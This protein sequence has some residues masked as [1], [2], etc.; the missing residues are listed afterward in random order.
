MHGRPRDYQQP[1]INPNAAYVI[2]LKPSSPIETANIDYGNQPAFTEIAATAR[3]ARGGVAVP[4][5]YRLFLLL[6][7]MELEAQQGGNGT[8]IIGWQP[9]GRAFKVHNRKEF[10]RTILPVHFNQTRFASFQRQLNLYGFHRLTAHGPDKGAVYHPCF[11]RGQ[12][13]LLPGIVRKK[14][15]GTKIRKKAPSPSDQPDFYMTYCHDEQQLQDILDH[16]KNRR[17]QCQ[18]GSPSMN[19]TNEQTDKDGRNDT[20]EF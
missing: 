6:E 19:N 15:K 17:Q 9:H 7:R 20:S 5:P 12:Q 3:I 16:F 1:S 2:G 10:V 13:F 4:F 18:Y 14:I 11:V 8:S